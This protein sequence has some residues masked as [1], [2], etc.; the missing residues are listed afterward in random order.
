MRIN[1]F[2]PTPTVSEY[3]FEKDKPICVFIG[4]DADMHL[5]LLGATVGNYDRLDIANRA[6]DPFYIIHTDVEVGD[7][8]YNVCYIYDRDED[9]IVGANFKGNTI[10]DEALRDCRDETIEYNETVMDKNTSKYGTF[11]IVGGSFKNKSSKE[12]AGESQITSTIFDAFIDKINKQTSNESDF[13]L[14]IYDL[15]ERVDEAVDVKL[16]LDRLATLGRQVF[17]SVGESY[18]TEKLIH[19]GVQIIKANNIN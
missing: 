19:P 9:H 12:I 17:I 13:P 15:F 6:K 7:K 1:K 16:W 4:Q 11:S 2:S 10:N 18:P 8:Q 3:F 14:F 5:S